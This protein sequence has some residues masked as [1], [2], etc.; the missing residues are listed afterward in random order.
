VTTE[1]DADPA[2]RNRNIDAHRPR[3]NRPRRPRPIPRR[4]GQ[5]DLLN[6]YIVHTGSALF[7]VPAGLSR[8]GDR[9]GK[10]LFTA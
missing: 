2:A 9:W 6:E 3:Q 5:H 1:A 8:P 4:L 10:R 7:V